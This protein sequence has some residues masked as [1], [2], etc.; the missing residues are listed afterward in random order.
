MAELALGDRSAHRAEYGGR[1]R[2]VKM[3]EVLNG[4]FYVRWTVVL[5]TGCL[6]VFKDLP[7][8]SPALGLALVGRLSREYGA[9][10][11]ALRR[12]IHARRDAPMCGAPFGQS[13]LS[14]ASQPLPNSPSIHSILQQG[15]IW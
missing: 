5:W 4:I 8:K 13:S 10:T 7:P 11:G 14:R 2:S 9:S 15:G 1:R 12:R 6:S 3:R